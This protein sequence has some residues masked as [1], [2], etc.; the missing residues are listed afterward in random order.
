MII[1]FSTFPRTQMPPAFIDEIISLF[2]RHSCEISTL[3]EKGPT[4]DQA[5][6]VL[7]QDLSDLGF[8]VEA[9]KKGKDRIKRPVFFGENAKPDLQY[10]V[11]AWH[12]KWRAGLEVEAA[13]AVGEMLSTAT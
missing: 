9:G 4:S 3:S 2:N 1:R 7:R 11:D 5:L 6:A 8:Q 12:P 13:R 10:E